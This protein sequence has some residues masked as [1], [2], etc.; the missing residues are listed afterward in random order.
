MGRASDRLARHGPFGHL[1]LR[2]IMMVIA[3]V[4]ITSF[5][6]LLLFSLPSCLHLHATSLSAGDAGACASSPYLSDTSLDTYYCS[7]YCTSTRTFHIMRAPSFSPSSDVSIIFP[8]FALFFLPNLLTSPTVAAA[9]RQMLIDAGTT[10]VGHAPDLSPCVPSR[11]IWWRLPRL[12][13]L[14]D[15]ESRSEILDNQC[16]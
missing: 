1:Y 8:A 15:E 7:G 10:R 2:T 11:R 9:S 16:P 3:L 12:G 13:Y 6:I 5:V 14:G 4:A